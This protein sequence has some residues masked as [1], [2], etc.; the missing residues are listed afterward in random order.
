MVL[1][2]SLNATVVVLSTFMMALPALLTNARLSV[3]AALALRKLYRAAPG[4]DEKNQPMTH[5]K[6]SERTW[7]RR[8]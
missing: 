8:W 4:S 2:L 7:H 1:R 5:G 3:F 6:A